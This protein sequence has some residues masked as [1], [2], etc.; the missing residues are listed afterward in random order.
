MRLKLYPGMLVKL[1]NRNPEHI[2]YIQMDIYE[3]KTWHSQRWA[4]SYRTINSDMVGMFVK[5]EVGSGWTAA[6]DVFLFED[7]LVG[8]PNDMLET[9]FEKAL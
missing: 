9:Y 6:S 8:F 7:I 4:G 2:R 5:H 1:I 3:H